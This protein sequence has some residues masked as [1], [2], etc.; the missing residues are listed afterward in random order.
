MIITYIKQDYVKDSITG[1]GTLTYIDPNTKLFGALGHEIIE[2]NTGQKLEKISN[3]T[4]RDYFLSAQEALE[5][6]L[7]DKIIGN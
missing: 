3:D 6:G 5:Y 4:E 1:V 2:K 7:V